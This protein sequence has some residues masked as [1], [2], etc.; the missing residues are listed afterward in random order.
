VTQSGTEVRH[1]RVGSSRRPAVRPGRR[2]KGVTCKSVSPG[3]V[4]R[5]CLGAV[6]RALARRPEGRGCVGDPEC[7]R[8]ARGEAQG[9]RVGRVRRELTG[10]VV[11]PRV[12]MPGES[13]MPWRAAS[14]SEGTEWSRRQVLAP[15][16]HRFGAGH[17]RAGG[18]ADSGRQPDRGA[19]RVHRVVVW[20]SRR[21]PSCASMNSSR[22][23][24]SVRAR[25]SRRRLPC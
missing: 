11:D 16:L 25:G 4:S 2:P 22:H 14:R 10:G 13:S 23:A 8:A 3:S 21:D 18:D 20:R 17:A 6:D 1:S 5:C 24:P 7:R 12:Q 9:G 19:S 15:V